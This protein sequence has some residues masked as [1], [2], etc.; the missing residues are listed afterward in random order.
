MNI[1][2]NRPFVVLEL[3]SL[4]AAK[5]LRE[6]VLL[7]LISLLER[8]FYHG[9]RRVPKIMLLDEAWDLFGNPNTANFIE[10]MYR[11]IRK[12]GGAVGTIVQSFLDY[13][14]KGNESVGQAILSNSE[15]KLCLQP[16][17][18]EL[19]ECQKRNLLAIPEAGLQIAQTVRT[20][21]GLYSEVLLLSSN[22]CSVFRF[23]PTPAE[24]VAFTTVAKE[25]QVYENIERSLRKS[26]TEPDPLMLLSLSGHANMLMEQGHSPEQ[27]ERITMENVE[28]AMKYGIDLF[29]AA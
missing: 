1:D 23:I 26:G 9:D 2:F 3:E 16:K 15:W 25:V 13:A 5:D 18:E 20:T 28:A 12:Y 29:H 14:N 22:Q 6:V 24:K 27:A 17:V 11:R 10:S 19:R 21:K 7:L 4:N 8:K